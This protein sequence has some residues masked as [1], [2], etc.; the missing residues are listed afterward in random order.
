MQNGLHH[1][2]GLG[3]QQE[4]GGRGLMGGA[5]TCSEGFVLQKR[6][7]MYVCSDVKS[8]FEW[9]QPRIK[10]SY[11]ITR[12][13]GQFSLD[14]PLTLKVGASVSTFLGNCGWMANRLL[15]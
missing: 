5:A 12:F 8:I 15:K 11:A 3:P 6:P 2:A 4:L 13:Y 7:L 10:D 14:K 9:Y 1:G